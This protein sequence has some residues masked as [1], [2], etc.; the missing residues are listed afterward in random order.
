MLFCMVSGREVN[1]LTFMAAQKLST[2]LLEMLP[3]AIK[4]TTRG[5]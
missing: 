4:A 1:I 3:L 5:E 2:T